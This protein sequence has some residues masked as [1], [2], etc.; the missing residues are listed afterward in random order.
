MRV[1]LTAPTS[2]AGFLAYAALIRS[3]V[4]GGDS[5][6]SFSGFALVPDLVRRVRPENRCEGPRDRIDVRD[7]ISAGIVRLWGSVPEAFMLPAT[8]SI[9]TPAC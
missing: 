1:T 8:P 3:A 6:F 2:L 4:D 7:T 5:D 9:T